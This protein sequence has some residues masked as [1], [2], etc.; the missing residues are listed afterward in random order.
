MSG[1]R[2]A[3]V[4]ANFAVMLYCVV[5]LLIDKHA[6]EHHNNAAVAAAQ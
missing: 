6:V 4:T 5:P 3:C 2:L 1:N